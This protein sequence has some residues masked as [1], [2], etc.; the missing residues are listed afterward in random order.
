MRRA[1][2]F[3]ELLIAAATIAILFVGLGAHLRGGIT[4][5]RRAT[6]TGAMV[7]RQHVALDQLERE[8][9]NAI[10]YDD[11]DASY[12]DELGL[13]PRPE[14]GEARLAWFAVPPMGRD[15]LPAIRF[16]TYACTQVDDAWGLW[17]T[18]QS[19]GEARARRE[20]V[21]Q[22]VLPDCEQLSVRY[23][24]ISPDSPEPLE[25]RSQWDEPE[26]GL[27]RLVEVTMRFAAGNRLTRVF[28][29]PAG[30]GTVSGTPP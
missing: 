7:Q 16:V 10:V 13:L 6:A 24:A 26:R 5:W 9:A 11:R 28:A 3:V 25:W 4:V 1:F 14:L 8:L 18:R 23:A 12:G 17:R 29:I 2:T 21:P 30:R 27:P 19:I 22:L 20:P 15:P